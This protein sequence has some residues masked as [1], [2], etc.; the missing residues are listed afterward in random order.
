MRSCILKRNKLNHCGIIAIPRS[1]Q[2]AHIVE[3]LDIFNFKLDNP[4]MKEIEKLDLNRIQFPEW[5]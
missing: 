5:S 2:K 1:S 4:D 3:N